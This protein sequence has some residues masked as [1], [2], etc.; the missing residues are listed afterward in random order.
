MA[1]DN[2]ELTESSL[3]RSF[4]DRSFKRGERYFRQGR[5][6]SA[7]RFSDKIWG[8]V[9]GTRAEPYRVTVEPYLDG[10]VSWC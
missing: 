2:L 10:V 6:V 7:V 1:M 8:M 5:V 4:D 9:D 3:R